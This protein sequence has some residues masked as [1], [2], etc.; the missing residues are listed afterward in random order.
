MALQRN[1]DFWEEGW[2]SGTVSQ[3]SAQPFLV[4]DSIQVGL[5][6]LRIGFHHRKENIAS[7]EVGPAHPFIEGFCNP[8]IFQ[9]SFFATQRVPK[10]IERKIRSSRCAGEGCPN[11]VLLRRVNKEIT[12]SFSEAR[13]KEIEKEMLIDYKWAT[14]ASKLINRA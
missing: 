5:E 13:E 9:R 11:L 8:L 7:I 6:V 10:T 2:S 12:S 3:R 4:L 14:E 1:E